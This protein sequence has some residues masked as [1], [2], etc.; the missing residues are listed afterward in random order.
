MASASVILVMGF[1]TALN[2]MA[3]KWKL[4]H[5]RGA[6]A[7]LDFTVLVVL[8][9]LFG[10]TISGLAI[11]TIASAIISLYLL[12]SPPRMDWFDD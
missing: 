2:L 1:F 10:G 3:I 9:W 7:G 12:V 4:E 11:A 6:D 5:D 8:A